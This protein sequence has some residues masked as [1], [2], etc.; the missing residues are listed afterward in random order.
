MGFDGKQVHRKDL[1][2]NYILVLNQISEIPNLGIF[3][4]LKLL[5]MNIATLGLH[6]GFSAR[7]RIL[8]IFS[9]QDGATKWY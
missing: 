2:K 9:L 6:L 1:F 8:Q 7:L 4:I 3:Q 5:Q